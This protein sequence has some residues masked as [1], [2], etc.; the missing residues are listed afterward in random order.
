M[1]IGLMGEHLEALCR[2]FVD[3]SEKRFECLASVPEFGFNRDR[4]TR[5]DEAWVGDQ[6]RLQL[7]NRIRA[8]KEVNARV[9]E[10]AD[11]FRGTSK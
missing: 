9:A 2:S 5:P 10:R 11:F 4:Q 6:R 1:G 7:L 8:R 3:R